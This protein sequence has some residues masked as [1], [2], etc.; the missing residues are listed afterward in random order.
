MIQLFVHRDRE[1][2]LTG[3][4]ESYYEGEYHSTPLR[5]SWGMENLPE[6]SST[7]QG[8]EC[9]AHLLVVTILLIQDGI[10]QSIPLTIQRPCKSLPRLQSPKPHRTTTHELAYTRMPQNL[11]NRTIL[12]SKQR[13]HSQSGC[14]STLGKN[15]RGLCF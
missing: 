11:S 13:Q 8:S 15:I 9:S 7:G 4:E 1:W 10:A 6:Y 2:I 3:R 14:R 12:N 5:P